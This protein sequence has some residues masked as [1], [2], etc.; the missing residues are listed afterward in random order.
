PGHNGTTEAR[1]RFNLLLNEQKSGLDWI[2]EEVLGEVAGVMYPSGGKL[3]PA[4]FRPKTPNLLYAYPG[5]IVEDQG[6]PVKTTI[7]RDENSVNTVRG[8]FFDEDKGWKTNTIEI[9]DADIGTDPVK[10]VDLQF[11][12]LTRESEVYRRCM[13]ELKKRILIKRSFAWKSPQTAQISEPFDVD[14]LSYSTVKDLR[15]K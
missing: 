11:D 4:I 3:R 5:N 10:A 12:S 8:T 2:K 1:D 15:G 9:Q 6:G 14:N 7:G 13:E